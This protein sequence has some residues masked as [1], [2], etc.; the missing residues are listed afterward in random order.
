[1][2]AN[3]CGLVWATHHR[4]SCGPNS[5]NTDVKL[6]TRV[7]RQPINVRRNP[8]IRK[9]SQLVSHP[10]SVC[11]HLLNSWFREK[12]WYCSFRIWIC[13][14]PCS[15]WYHC[16]MVVHGV[17]VIQVRQLSELWPNASISWTFRS[18][19]LRTGTMYV[20]W[21]TVLLAI[22]NNSAIWAD[23]VPI[24]A[25]DRYILGLDWWD[26]PAPLHTS[27]LIVLFNQHQHLWNSRIC[28]GGTPSILTQAVIVNI[29]ASVQLFDIAIFPSLSCFLGGGPRDAYGGNMTYSLSISSRASVPYLSLVR[30][31]LPCQFIVVDHLN[32]ISCCCL[33]LVL[34][35]LSKI[36][37]YIH[38]A[39][40]GLVS[41]AA[42]ET[43]NPPISMPGKRTLPWRTPMAD[44]LVSSGES[45]AQA[46][47]LI[48]HRC[49]CWL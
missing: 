41:F 2:V 20:L 44:S 33:W 37:R 13:F 28:W 48:S 16:S 8:N 3:P 15:C 6:I 12:S 32:R 1:M 26:V 40:T 7:F 31:Y 46:F 5:S 4:D 22:A 45:W 38:T 18:L 11:C 36:T 43:S 17:H 47:Y 14:A 29:G 23:K 34:W 25:L 21:Y 30:L 39:C 24:E 35:I 49:Q 42:S 10:F 19:S 9:W 27:S